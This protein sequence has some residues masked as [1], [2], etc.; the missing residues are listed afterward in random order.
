MRKPQ[1]DVTIRTESDNLLERSAKLFA[2][3]ALQSS[4][5]V[6]LEAWDLIP[7]PKEDWDYYGQSLSA[8]FVVD[9]ADLGDKKSCQ[10]WVEIM[11]QM[12]DDPNHEDHY[13]LMQEGEAMYK[14][15]DLERAF[16]VFSRIEELYGPRGFEGEQRA[17]LAF[18][19]EQRVKRAT[20]G[21]RGG[22]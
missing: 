11:A 9:Y 8:G 4:L 21:F 12:Y 16:Y 2:S 22:E 15:G 10:K 1:I 20:A 19:E 18:I 7:E 14:L 6:A 3:G 13:V 5:S 17:Y